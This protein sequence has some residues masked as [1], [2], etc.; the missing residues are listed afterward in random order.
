MVT[1]SDFRYFFSVIKVVPR[2]HRHRVSDGAFSRFDGI[3][4]CNRRMV[5]QTW[6]RTDRHRTILG[7]YTILAKH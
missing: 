7:L 2:R 6:R 1:S 5:A 4:A 3:P